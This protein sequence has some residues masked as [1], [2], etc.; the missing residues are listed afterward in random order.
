MIVKE[1]LGRDLLRIIIWYPFRWLI[2][3]MPPRRAFGLFAALGRIYDHFARSKKREIRANLKAVM[4]GRPELAWE[5]ARVMRRYFENHFISQLQIFTFPRLTEE[6][7]DSV[8]R[9]EGLSRITQVLQK[10]RKGCI[11]VHGHF[12]PIQL[13]LCILGLKGCPMNQ[14]IHRRG[15]DLSFIGE[16]VQLRLRTR[17]ENQI[18]A[19][20]ISAYTY[21][22]PLVR[23]L[24][25]NQVVM[26][27]GDGTGHREV[28]GQ[29]VGVSILGQGMRFPVGPMK[30]AVMTG[31]PVFPAFT[32][33]ENKTRFKTIIGDRIEMDPR[34]EPRDQLNRGV[35]AFASLLE[36]GIE[37][38]P[39]HWHFWDNFKPG[40]LIVD[41]ESI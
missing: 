41:H 36:D 35:R 24:K 1:S 13:P 38:H 39:D 17:Y 26:I 5:P 7:A 25:D 15:E 30:L 3:L 6:N 22:R 37:K 19:R 11:L 23:A 8:L 28:I 29:T 14:V 4:A 21:L 31:A 33:R 27:A 34:L 18:P 2:L 20:L 16:K 32:F 12:G 9:V 10:E 40:V